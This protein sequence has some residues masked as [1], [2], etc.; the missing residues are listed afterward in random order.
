MPV[1][2]LSLA[3]CSAGTVSRSAGLGAP[4]PPRYRAR[5][6][7]RLAYQRGAAL[8]LGVTGRFVFGPVRIRQ[9]VIGRLR[10]RSTRPG[11]DGSAWCRSR[12]R[13][14]L[15]AVASSCHCLGSGRGEVI[16]AEYR[17]RARVYVK[18]LAA[19]CISRSSSRAGPRTWD[20]RS[21]SSLYAPRRRSVGEPDA[22]TGRLR[23]AAR[24][25][26]RRGRRR[27]ARRQRQ[28]GQHH[29]RYRR[30]GLD[31]HR[32]TYPGATARPKTAGLGASD[33]DGDGLTVA[34]LALETTRSRLDVI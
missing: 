29:H 17:R 5:A 26:L 23:A 16:V 27:P 21:T 12:S 6:D 24:R 3:A 20:L 28:T 31:P 33:G 32:P 13:P 34:D 22:A 8:R 18:T 15:T 11:R 9:P 2:R 14:G 1:T 4:K 10:R 7:Q 19:P 30:T 25:P